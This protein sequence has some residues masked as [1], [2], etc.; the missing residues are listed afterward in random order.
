M[1]QKMQ[2][3]LRARIEAFAADIVA[4]LQRAVADSVSQA[5]T[6]A[7]VSAP[8]PKRR[9]RPPSTK[10]VDLEVLFREISREGDRRS[11]QIAKALGTSTK[12]LV[13]PLKRLLNDKRIK[14]KG[15]ARGTS[16][17]SA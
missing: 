12:S 5:L 13:S 2:E 4:V 7:T 3:E 11:E 16:Y 10:S 15:K 1:N 14:A 17:R 6:G 9:G 8:A